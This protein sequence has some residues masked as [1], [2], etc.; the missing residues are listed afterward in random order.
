MCILKQFLK[1]IIDGKH[2]RNIVWDWNGTILDDCWL[3]I[4]SINSLLRF[5]NLKPLD[6]ERYHNIFGFPVKD[7]YAKA[8]FDF[9]KEPFE[10]PALQFIEL[11]DRRKKT[12]RLVPSVENT[13]RRLN[14]QGYRQFVLSAS[15]ARVLNEMIHHYHLEGLFES[16]YGLPNHFA[17]GK[18]GLALDMAEKLQLHSNETLLIGDTCHDKDVADALGWEVIL[19]SGG[20][21]P[22]HRLASCQTILID[23]FQELIPWISPQ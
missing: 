22:R 9:T 12:C 4:E 15:E 2:I 19:F 6:K 17:A 7:Y 18:A 14:Q 10:I 1:M 23:D 3:C 21:F 13:I 20:H 16:V 5:R 8:G 11:Y